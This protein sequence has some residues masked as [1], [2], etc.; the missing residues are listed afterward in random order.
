MKNSYKLIVALNII[1][2][3]VCMTIDIVS[4]YV[5][6]TL[7][8]ILIWDV[9]YPCMLVS[10]V[11]SIVVII[12]K[13]KIYRSLVITNYIIASFYLLFLLRIFY[14]C[15]LVDINSTE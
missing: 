2:F 3:L 6:R 15:F 14:V 4:P 5:S 9:F 10:M 13:S 8:R 12:H 11:L 1:L 7:R